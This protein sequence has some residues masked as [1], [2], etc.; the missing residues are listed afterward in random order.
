VPKSKKKWHMNWCET[1]R[2]YTHG[3]APFIQWMSWI[4]F[5]SSLLMALVINII[6]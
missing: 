2:L 5:T 3:V 4:N 6:I 1:S